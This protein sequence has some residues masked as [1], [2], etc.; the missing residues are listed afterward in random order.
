MDTFRNR[1]K[2]AMNYRN[3][4]QAELANKTG[5][6]KPRINQYVNGVYEAKQDALSRIAEALHVNVTWLMGY[7]VEM[8]DMPSIDGITNISTPAA[9]AI[10]IL[11]SICA[12]N[13][14]FCEE[15]YDGFFFVDNSIRADLC[16]NVK[17]DS[18]IE[19]DIYDGDK[20]F[21][22]QNCL[23]EDGRIYAVRINNESEAVLKRV[24][25]QD[26]NVILSSSNPD[27]A[28]IIE[29]AENVSIIGECIGVYHAVRRK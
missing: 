22:C 21:I 29:K 12:G 28:P 6:S 19:S 11:G 17:G 5:L 14:I 3:I 25:R 8:F 27:Y 9:R 13:G 10:P 4:T 18:M 15:N 7:D 23:I 1:L 20:A 24:F 16:L 26:E 2:D